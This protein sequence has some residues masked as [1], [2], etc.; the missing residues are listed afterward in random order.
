MKTSSCSTWFAPNCSRLPSPFTWN[1]PTDKTYFPAFNWSSV[2]YMRQSPSIE[3]DGFPNAYSKVV[4][5][6]SVSLRSIPSTY[7]L[8]AGTPTLRLSIPVP[9]IYRSR[10]SVTD[11]V[12]L[13]PIGTFVSWDFN[14][15]L[16]FVSRPSA[17]TT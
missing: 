13:F 10:P 11:V 2:E 7:T 4:S 14:I 6:V 3:L 16:P 12:R 8:S 9:S 15:A 5:E 1:A 17:Y